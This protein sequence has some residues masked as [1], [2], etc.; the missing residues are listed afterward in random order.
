MHDGK[1]RA[2]R[3]DPI[4]AAPARRAALERSAI[5]SAVVG[6]HERRVRVG[7][8]IA[9]AGEI[10]QEREAGAVDVERKNRAPRVDGTGRR[11]LEG[12]AVQFAVAPLNERRGGEDI[13]AVEGREHL[14]AGAVRRD[15][16]H[17][18]SAN[19]AARGVGAADA[20]AAIEKAIAG[21]EKA[22]I[23]IVAIGGPKLVAFERVDDRESGPIAV[24]LEDVAAPVGA[25]KAARAIEHAVSAEQ[26]GIVFPVEVTL[27]A[28]I[29]GER[30]EHAIVRAVGS[31]AVNRAPVAGA[32]LA[33]ES[34]ENSVPVLHQR[35]HRR[36]ALR[37]RIVEDVD[38]RVG[39]R[40]DRP[41]AEAGH[42]D[43][44][45]AGE[46]TSQRVPVRG[47]GAAETQEGR[48]LRARKPRGAMMNCH[49]GGRT[50]DV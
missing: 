19:S 27:P 2:V 17:D 32:A 29:G 47:D 15:L 3:V 12:G 1:A 21:H 38:H 25:A 48:P 6:V 23:R 40:E 22:S 39:L 35:A 11:T 20:G 46:N 36:S 10:I 31:D 16:V 13:R 5:E 41:G 9:G 34:V 33:R 18:A 50:K 28:R 30:V 45:Q 44:G 14:I 8:A 42:P 4:H 7:A 43:E 24:D 49:G 37:R 26:P